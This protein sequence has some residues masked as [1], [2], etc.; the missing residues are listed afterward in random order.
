MTEILPGEVP[1]EQTFKK[2]TI[3]KH[4]IHI[5]HCKDRFTHVMELFQENKILNVF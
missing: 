5:M 4:A 2:L 1:V 3:K